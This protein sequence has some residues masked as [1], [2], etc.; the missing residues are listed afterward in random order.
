MC[1]SHFSHL[2][3]F[4]FPSSLPFSGHLAIL[5]LS[6]IARECIGSIL[7]SLPVILHFVTLSLDHEDPIVTS[8]SKALLHI[9]VQMLSQRQ[10]GD[11]LDHP[12]LI[13]E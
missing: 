3:F 9:L 11:G 6:E 4:L 2:I 5:L 8:H 7:P 12:V 13:Q 10:Q 1:L